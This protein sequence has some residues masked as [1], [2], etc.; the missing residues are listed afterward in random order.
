M[1][2]RLA[3]VHALCSQLSSIRGA[4]RGSLAEFGLRSLLT[5]LHED[6]VDFVA[7]GGV[8][9]GAAARLHPH[10]HYLIAA[11][12]AE[13]DCGVLHADSHLHVGWF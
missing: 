12:A 3:R 13:R 4:A 10:R 5:A 2:E 9:V 1:S 11:A 8:A 6:G 7:I